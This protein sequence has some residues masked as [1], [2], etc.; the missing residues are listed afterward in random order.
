MVH[1]IPVLAPSIGCTRR[2]LLVI[3]DISRFKGMLMNLS[4]RLEQPLKGNTVPWIILAHVSPAT[5]TLI[6]WTGHDFWLMQNSVPAL[7]KSNG[8]IEKSADTKKRC[9][10][11]IVLSLLQEKQTT[12]PRRNPHLA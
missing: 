9:L 7:P 12:K 5:K 1:F 4:A 10:L 6:A 3:A 11:S 2:R 8:R